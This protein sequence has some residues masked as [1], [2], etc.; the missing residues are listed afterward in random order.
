MILHDSTSA[1]K[2]IPNKE[3][4]HISFNIRMYLENLT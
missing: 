2:K 3:H 1:S 4:Y